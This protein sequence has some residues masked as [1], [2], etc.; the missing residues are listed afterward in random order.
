[1]P[2]GHNATPDTLRVME[3]LSAPRL[4]SYMACCNADYRAALDLYRWNTGITGAFWETLSHLEITLRNALDQRLY[5]RH[6][7]AG[8]PGSWLDNPTGELTANAVADIAKAR[9]QVTRKGKQLSDEQ[10]IAELGFGFWRYLL[11]RR[12]TNLWPDLRGAFPQAPNR[13]RETVEDPVARLYKFRN[14]LAHHEPVWNQ[15]VPDL[16]ADLL[17]VLGYLDPALPTW[18][19]RTCRVDRVLRACPVTWL[20]PSGVATHGPF[21]RPAGS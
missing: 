15:P 17:T 20:F 9:S 7:K 12:Y 1:V 10:T 3:L 21:P 2:P 18:A 19:T 8:R 4:S 6:H 5:L 14:R 13:R 11:A 16:Y